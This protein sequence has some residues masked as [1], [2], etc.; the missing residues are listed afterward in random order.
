MWIR[1]ALGACVVALVAGC[2]VA[3][4]HSVM[5]K[6]LG[7]P[8]AEPRPPAPEPD[9]KELVRVGANTLS[10]AH[11]MAVAVSRPRRVTDQEFSV[12]VKANVSSLIDGQARPVTLLVRIEHGKLADRHRA[13]AHDGCEIETYEKVEPQAAP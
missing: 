8:S 10:T 12:C 2:G 11:P 9:A 1:M 4:Q 6:I 7:Q 13:A 3:D 5:P